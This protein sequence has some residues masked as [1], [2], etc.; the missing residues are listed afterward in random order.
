MGSQARGLTI[1][2]DRQTGQDVR[3]ANVTAV[4]TISNVLKSSL[5][6]QGLDKM[7]VDEVGD[8]TVSN[9]GATILQMLEVEHPA[10]KVLVDLSRLQDSEVGD[11]T[12]SVVLVAAELLKRANELAKS[13][14]HPTSIIS[15]YRLAMKESIKYVQEALAVKGDTLGKD[16]FLNVARTS[17]SS[18]ILGA[19]VDHFGQM[20]VDAMMS[21]KMTN[22]S[23]K[24]KYPVGQI[25]VMK[26]HGKSALES[27]LIPNGYALRLGKA[28]QQ[29]PLRVSPAKI[30]LIDFN[31]QKHKM[32]MGVEIKV[33]NPDE[34]EKIRQKE[35]DITRDRIQKIIASGANAIF[36]SKGIDDMSLKYFIEAGAIAVRRV[37]AKDLK[38]IAKTTGAQ[39]NITLSTMEG[40]EKFDPA[41]LGHAE[42]VY[43]D[44]VGDNDHIF[45]K[46]CKN[47]R[48]SSIILRGA[49]EF[50]LDEM[51]RALHDALCALSKTMESNSVV[52][53]GGAV[54]TAL[55][56]YLEDFARTLGSRE[57][58]AVAEFA[59]A[60][61]TIPKTLANN[62]ALD[63][64]DLTARLRVHHNAA[65]VSQEPAKKDYRYYGLDL[66]N[67]KVRNSLTAGVLEPMV[68]KLKSLKFATEAAITIIRIDDMIKLDPE[69]EPKDPRG[70]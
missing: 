8:V 13:N 29:M 45:I 22:D 51:E 40:D 44:R 26:S 64:V 32:Q 39:I 42:E 30:A 35:M 66:T 28:A 54:E 4:T 63:A 46:G 2:G 14:N 48:A 20:A 31:L 67:N 5:G 57:Q 61:L 1:L 23:G 3:S 18:K 49:N 17:L 11:G 10:A 55:S 15:G 36:C 24:S 25:N 21:V 70:Q 59:E 47:S 50:M 56:I 65:Q 43:E 62:A 38:R 19:E 53:G 41:T 7:L 27:A 34:L 69:P 58:L 12:T 52:P 6:P 16:V 37:D 33:E 9:D 60:L 68:S